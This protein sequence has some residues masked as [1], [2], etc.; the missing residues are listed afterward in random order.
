MQYLLIPTANKKFPD[1]VH[2]PYNQASLVH[3]ENTHL[4]MSGML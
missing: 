1:D 2:Q 4:V 3:L